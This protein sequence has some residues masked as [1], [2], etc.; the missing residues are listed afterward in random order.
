MREDTTLDMT[1]EV[2]R[3]NR[4]ASRW[5]GE[6]VVD[7]T[8]IEMFHDDPPQVFQ[9]YLDGE[10]N[11]YKLSSCTNRLR[12]WHFHQYA[13]A[14]LNEGRYSWEDLALS[15]RYARAV[16]E[17]ETA[18]AEAGQ[19]GSV[20]QDQAVL[21]YSLNVLAGWREDAA[22]IGKLLHRGLD[23]SLLD[24]RHTPRHE[25]GTFYR[26]FWF[27]MHL[28]CDTAGI[29]L[30]TSPYSYPEDMSPYRDVLADWRTPDLAKVQ[31]FVSAMTDFHVLE[32]EVRADLEG[33]PNEIS[34]FNT[35]PRMLFPHEILTFLRLREEAGL[36]N[37]TSF[38]HPL[39]NQPLAKLP[40]PVPLPRPA[41]PL[42]DQVIEKFK[43]DYPGSFGGPAG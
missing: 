23:T 28:N 13:H 11:L 5:M 21:Y 4:K 40:G 24:L 43:R 39:M 1:K 37:P 32:A 12:G 26:H 19:G 18:F 3:F 7:E 41:T 33:E 6:W 10:Y 15:A 29:A 30:D 2:T 17:F 35:E 22:W 42:L 25:A 31:R 38:D 36:E 27:L 8:N 14:A 9:A 34:E 20:L 16:V